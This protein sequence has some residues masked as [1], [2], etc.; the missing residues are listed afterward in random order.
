MLQPEAVKRFSL[1]PCSPPQSACSHE[2]QKSWWRFKTRLWEAP[3]RSSLHISG[4]KYCRKVLRCWLQIICKKESRKSSYSPSPPR[5]GSLKAP[6]P[7]LH[8]H[9]PRKSVQSYTERALSTQLS[10]QQRGQ[11]RPSPSG[12]SPTSHRTLHCFLSRPPVS[13]L[14]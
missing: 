12:K 11:P 4:S 8:V 13:L 2:S 7:P 1:L 14:I 5:Q 9:P 6:F 10:A 3:A